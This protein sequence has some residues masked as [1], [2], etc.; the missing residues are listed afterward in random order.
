TIAGAR[1]EKGKIVLVIDCYHGVDLQALR[2]RL[3]DGMDADLIVDA[4]QCLLPPPVLEEKFERYIVPSD[5]TYGVY[6]VAD[7]ADY[8]DSRKTEDA[9]AAIGNAQGLTV[10][11]GVAAS[12]IAEGDVLVFGSM[13][14]EGVSRRLREGLANWGAAN[15]ELEYIQKEKRG[16]ALDWH[17]L[18]RHKRNLLKRMD[19][20]MCFDKEEQPFLLDG[21][22]FRSE[23]RALT[24]RPF[25]CVPLFLPA[26]WGGD[27]MQK[28]L[29]V[30]K[31]Q[32]NVGWGIT[33]FLE[34]Q[35]LNLGFR[36]GII[37]FPA[38]DLVSLFP[39]ECLGNKIFYFWGYKCPLHVNFLDTWNGGNLSLQV[40]PT[41]A[42]AFEVFNSSY[43][44][45]ESYY[46]F[47]A[48]PQSGVYLG[49]KQ[50]VRKEDFVEALKQAQET[51]V[52]DDTL[53]V[54][55]VPVK[56][57]DHVFIP[58][59][60]V[61]SSGA[62]GVVLE[63]DA[64]TFATFKLWDWG[65]VDLDGKPRP[66]NIDHGQHCI[67]EKF[68]GEFVY[69]RLVGKQPET[70]RGY[71]WRKEDSSTINYEPMTVNRYWFH[72]RIYLE[73]NDNIII[74]ALVEG[75]E[76]VIESCDASFKPLTIHYAEAV[77]VPADAKKYLLRPTEG[78]AFEE[79]CVLEIFYP[80]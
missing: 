21:E 28:V 70:G 57:H 50:G 31:D 59:G 2:A 68:Q 7:V 48:T 44:H 20:F 41:A 17:I 22:V 49:L 18:N 37:A 36:D 19:L 80:M 11:Y 63:I 64:F 34:I 51:G 56:K 53:Y 65:R 45:H 32:P 74:L 9:R 35:S 38:Q 8:F 4:T 1:S 55:K 14:K 13:T 39:T 5:R 77:F 25:K 43:G 3:I 24:K 72:D 71:G 16:N 27:W 78:R 23:V 6:A 52:M 42:Y 26:V 60:T 29:G 76:A 58:G 75:G 54:N 46:I 10:V 73:T 62:G 40:H 12:F 61:H 79:L 47:D 15:R 67:Q 33:G 30:C 69:D 66:I